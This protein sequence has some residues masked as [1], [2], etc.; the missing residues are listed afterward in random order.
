IIGLLNVFTPSKSID[1]FNDLY[2]VSH[3]MGADLN[4][5]I[6]TQKLSEDHYFHSAGIIH[7]DLKPSNIA[8]NEDCELKIRTLALHDPQS[9]K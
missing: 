7:R 4:K 9:M 6:K 5:I 2:L 3:L 1:E 8:V